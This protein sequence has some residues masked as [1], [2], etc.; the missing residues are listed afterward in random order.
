M[1]RTPSLCHL[2]SNICSSYAQYSFVHTEKSSDVMFK[3]HYTELRASIEVREGDLR[4]IAPAAACVDCHDRQESSAVQC[5]AGIR[6]QLQIRTSCQSTIAFNTQP[7]MS[8]WR[9]RGQH[10]VTSGRHSAVS[11]SLDETR[12][13]IQSHSR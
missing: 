13:L 12:P 5:K 11:G 6:I 9:M 4:F 1:A 3:F 7:F 2:L 10:R 8:L